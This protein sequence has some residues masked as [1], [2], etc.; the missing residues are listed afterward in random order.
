[1]LNQIV[2]IWVVALCSLLYGYQCFGRTCCPCSVTEFSAM[3]QNSCIWRVEV[4]GNMVSQSEQELRESRWS[5][6][7][8]QCE[9][10]AWKAL[11]EL[12]EEETPCPFTS[13]LSS[14]LIHFD[15]EN[16]GI[17]FIWNICN[18]LQDY[19]VSSVRPQPELCD[20]EIAYKSSVC[21]QFFVPYENS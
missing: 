17:R 21:F 13:V 15:P 19:T 7:P 11:S 8:W 6:C 9:W 1:M 4:L 20:H 18:H 16:V 3:I 12:L 14:G 10:G 2:V 5:L